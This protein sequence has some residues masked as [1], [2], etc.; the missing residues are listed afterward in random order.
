[1]ASTW[2]QWITNII[3]EHE[4]N[5]WRQLDASN[6]LWC[7]GFVEEV[8]LSMDWKCEGIVDEESKD[9]LMISCMHLVVSW[10][11]KISAGKLSVKKI[12]ISTVYESKFGHSLTYCQFYMLKKTG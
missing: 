6:S 5:K 2:N 11:I 12:P 8:F 3:S 4:I 7:E 10:E 1:M 9:E